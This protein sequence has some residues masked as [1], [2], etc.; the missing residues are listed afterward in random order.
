MTGTLTK[1][2]TDDWAARKTFGV[3]FSAYFSEQPGYSERPL[4]K[5]Q[6][7]AA[8]WVNFEL[9][10][11]EE[12]MS[13]RSTEIMFPEKAEEFLP[14]TPLGRELLSLRTRAIEEGMR[15]LSADEVLEEVRRRREEIEDDETDLR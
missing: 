12:D 5:S 8:L 6:R 7:R 3:L 14:G 4:A 15:L 9:P 1:R 13:C 10:I 2:L 11:H